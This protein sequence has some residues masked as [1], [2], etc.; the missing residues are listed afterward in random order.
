MRNAEVPGSCLVQHE[1]QALPQ[2]LEMRKVQRDQITGKPTLPG[3]HSPPAGRGG[4]GTNSHILPGVSR[5]SSFSGDRWPGRARH[6]RRTSWNSIP[7][8]PTWPGDTRAQQFQL[9]LQDAKILSTKASSRTARTVIKRHPVFKS[10]NKN[11]GSRHGVP[12][13]REAE[14]GG[15]LRV[16]GLPGL[17]SE[18]QN[19]QGYTVIPCLKKRKDIV[20][21]AL[22]Q[23]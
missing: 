16:Q 13:L 8:A 3:S 7:A 20:L 5:N 11:F 4:P 1:W 12:T 15:S 22:P 18:F 10:K 6:V 2:P 9:F 21:P 14:A 19:S 17:H 23:L